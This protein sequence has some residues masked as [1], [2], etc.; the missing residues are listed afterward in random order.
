MYATRNT[1]KQIIKIQALW[2]GYIY[3][4]A[5][6][7]ALHQHREQRERVRYAHYLELLRTSPQ[8]G[9]HTEILFNANERTESLYSGEVIEVQYRGC[10]DTKI[11]VQFHYDGEVRKYTGEKFSL[12]KREGEEHKRKLGIEAGFTGRIFTNPCTIKKKKKKKKKKHDDE[13]D[14]FLLDY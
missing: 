12:L 4:K 1:T 11:K 13:G 7:I 5:Y 2:R 3:K 8:V 10:M 6:P 14:L 9:D